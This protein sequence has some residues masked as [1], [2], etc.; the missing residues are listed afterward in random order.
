MEDTATGYHYAWDAHKCRKVFD[1]DAKEPGN[2]SEISPDGSILVLI[3]GGPGLHPLRLYDVRRRI[4]KAYA[5]EELEPYSER[6]SSSYNPDDHSGLL[7]HARFSPDGRLLAVT[8]GDNRLHVYDIRVLSRGPLCRFEH[9]DS[10]V[11]GGRAY[12]VVEAQWV[13]GRDRRRIGIVSGG[14]DG[15]SRLHLLQ[16]L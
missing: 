4:R 8:R 7:E 14:N 11:G 15:W 13:E 5:R 9:C 10:D 16:M 12:G 2:A 3:T 6:S 1:L